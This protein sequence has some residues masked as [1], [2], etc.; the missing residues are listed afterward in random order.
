M[1][2]GSWGTEVAMTPSTVAVRQNLDLIVTT[3]RPVPGLNANDNYPVGRH[4]GRTGPGLAVRPR[5]DR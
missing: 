3:A 1:N 4:P 5:G 2:I